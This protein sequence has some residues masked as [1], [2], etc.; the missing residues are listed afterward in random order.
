MQPVLYSGQVQFMADYEQRYPEAMSQLVF[1]GA[2]GHD[3]FPDCLQMGIEYF[4]Q[5]RFKFQ[6]YEGC[7]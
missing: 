2:Y 4:M 1:Y 6:R 3:D 5:P 7:L